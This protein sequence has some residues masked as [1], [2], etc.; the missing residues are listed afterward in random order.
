MRRLRYATSIAACGL[1]LVACGHPE[2]TAEVT[3]APVLP[4][5]GVILPEAIGPA[6]LEQCSRATPR[7]VKGYWT[8]SDVMIYEL[9][10]ALPQSLGSAIQDATPTGIPLVEPQEFYRQYIGIIEQNG[11][12]KI[13]VN[14]FHRHHVRR[15]NPGFAG[16][17]SDTV[18]WRLQ[19][20]SV[21]DGG[22]LYFGVEYD[23][24]R[25]RFSAVRFNKRVG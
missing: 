8:P 10:T 9:E 3:F 12:R 16:G 4:V 19:A 24:N 21:C 17:Q 5:M 2:S 23:P 18:S 20:V 14:G 6:L 22:T 25:Q 11:R 7:T 13:Y 15:S 1:L